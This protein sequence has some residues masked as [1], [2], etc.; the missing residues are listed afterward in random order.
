[1]RSYSTC[2]FLFDLFHLAECTQGPSKLLQMARFPT[3]YGQVIFHYMSALYFLYPLIRWWTCRLF[4]CLAIVSN[5]WNACRG[6]RYLLDLVLSFSLDKYLEL[7]LLDHM[8]ILFLIFWGDTILFPIVVTPIYSFTSSAQAFLFLHILAKLVISCLFDNSLSNK[9]EAVVFICISLMVSDVEHLLVYLLAICMSSLEKCL[10][11][12]S[13]H[14]LIGLLFCYWVVWPLNFAY[15]P[16]IRYMVC[17]YSLLFSRLPFHFV[18]GFICC[19]EVFSVWCS[20]TCLFLLSL[21]LLL[22]LNPPNCL[23]R[24]IDV[25]K[26]TDCILHF[27]LGVLWFQ[28]LCSSL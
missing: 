25:R 6:C 27:L 20:P 17:T 12:S 28:V 18:G 19:A 23:P 21:L 8:V 13:D 26:L 4:P 7:Q 5:A 3:F 9:C 1:M 16:L 14:F 22:V 24:L 10:F 2:L 11:I 15:Y